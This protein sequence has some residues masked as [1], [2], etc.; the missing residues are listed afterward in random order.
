MRLSSVKVEN[1]MNIFF[2]VSTIYT[3]LSVT[4]RMPNAWL[5]SAENALHGEMLPKL[6][7]RRA[8][9]FSRQHYG[10]PTIVYLDIA[11]LRS[12]TIVIKAPT[13]CVLQIV[14]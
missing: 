7:C 9:S 12:A 11:S 2:A 8:G 6:N 13:R 14:P 4:Q 5:E 10:A 1:V 3:I